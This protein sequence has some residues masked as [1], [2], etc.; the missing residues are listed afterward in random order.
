MD[1]PW[2][3]PEAVAGQPSENL[4]EAL[5][6]SA[7]CQQDMPRSM[8]PYPADP[9]TTAS[10]K[11]VPVKPSTK[12]ESDD[13]DKGENPLLSSPLLS[14]KSQHGSD[15]VMSILS[16]KNAVAW[17]QLRLM[18]EA[19]HVQWLASTTENQTTTF[20]GNENNFWMSQETFLA[21]DW[22]K[23]SIGLLHHVGILCKLLCP[24][25]HLGGQFHTH[26]FAQQC[27][28]HAN[29]DHLGTFLAFHWALPPGA[30]QSHA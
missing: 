18:K 7:S 23:G 24:S 20:P 3:R 11:K 13:K 21:M 5:M 9:R 6:A 14:I 25:V 27:P 10:P 8:T 28:F 22:C 29:L 15:L 4:R 12:P 2:S 19:L 30:W 17:L 16:L 1:A 26:G